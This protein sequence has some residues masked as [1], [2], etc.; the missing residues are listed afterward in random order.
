MSGMGIYM[1]CQ[2]NI[3]LSILSPAVVVVLAFSTA[4]R[5]IF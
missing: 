5:N 1:R 2:Q 3:T 4:Q